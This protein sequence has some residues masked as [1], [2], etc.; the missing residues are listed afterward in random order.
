M[1]RP[2]SNSVDEA[3]AWVANFLLGLSCSEQEVSAVKDFIMG[4]SI[5]L[6]VLIDMSVED[7]TDK[8][9]LKFGHAKK[10]KKAWVRAAFLAVLARQLED[11][12]V[13]NLFK[14]P[15]SDA[16]FEL[17]SDTADDGE[18]VPAKPDQVLALAP[19]V[20]PIGT[21]PSSCWLLPSPM[22][23]KMIWLV[24]SFVFLTSA[25]LWREYSWQKD[26]CDELLTCSAGGTGKVTKSF[27]TVQ[28]FR[29]FL[30]PP[31]MM[32]YNQIRANVWFGTS[33]FKS[34]PDHVSNCL[35]KTEGVAALES[36]E[37]DSCVFAIRDAVWQVHASIGDHMLSYNVTHIADL[38]QAVANTLYE[39]G[40][41]LH[42]NFTEMIS[43]KDVPD[44]VA[45]FDMWARMRTFMEK[46]AAST[47]LQLKELL[48]K[49]KLVDEQAKSKM[50]L[51]ALIDQMLGMVKS[52]DESVE[53][54]KSDLIF[55]SSTLG[56]AL[57]QHEN[58]PELSAAYHEWVAHLCASLR[59]VSQD[60]ESSKL[61]ATFMF[62][63]IFDRLEPYLAGCSLGTSFSDGKKKL[64]SSLQTREGV[65]GVRKALE[66]EEGWFSRA[67]GRP[68]KT[69]A[70]M[71]SVETFLENGLD[72][73]EELQS[74]DSNFDLVL[75]FDRFEP[76]RTEDAV[77]A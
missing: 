38:N 22:S 66:A 1:Q 52:P 17:V 69:S 46:T 25:G 33:C 36:C 55:I 50:N 56:Q 77:V 47:N 31:K 5:D 19:A 43:S 70:L 57:Q 18:Y 75:T 2:Q 40:V 48:G 53:V 71:S 61:S 73:L 37:D 41:L 60:L 59:V 21:P 63:A 26:L 44:L 4:E 68:G 11:I 72:K 54:P 42:K 7:F 35:Q 8:M 51:T 49:M 15:S 76:F 39:R 64:A 14:S 20:G 32:D 29:E 74:S 13:L 3:A 27:E 10:L 30:P 12:K 58:H 62:V 28:R 23:Q 24:C 67:S 16:S 45:F 65:H 6:E 9:H 34:I